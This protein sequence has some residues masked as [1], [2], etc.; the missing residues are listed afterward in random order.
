MQLM[1]PQS[2]TR[3]FDAKHM[4]KHPG[5]LFAVVTIVALLAP[6]ATATGKLA[7]NQSEIMPIDA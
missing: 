6:S 3:L 5:L 4:T 7:G 2:R 1:S